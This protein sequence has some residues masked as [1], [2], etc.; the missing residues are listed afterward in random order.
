MIQCLTQ[1]Q[2]PQRP[3]YKSSS[4]SEHLPSGLPV[5]R[6]SGVQALPDQSNGDGA[7]R[8]SFLP[9]RGLSKSIPRAMGLANTPA[10]IEP[11]DTSLDSVDHRASSDP[12]PPLHQA[13]AHGAILG[14]SRPRSMYQAASARPDK[15]TRENDD[16]LRRAIRPTDAVSR[17]PLSTSLSRSQSLRRPG[18]PMQTTQSTSSR[19]HTR[20]QSTST[21]AGTKKGS[22]ETSSRMDRPKSLLM[23]PSQLTKPGSA[24]PATG[25]NR[26][27]AR[28]EA[29]K[30]SASTRA[31]ADPVRT[32]A[33]T[34]V[35]R[36]TTESLEL[37]AQHREEPKDELKRSARP[38]FTTL[39]QHFTPR[40]V[41]KAAT[42]TFLHPAP[43]TSQT[44]PSEI[45]SLQSELL[46]LHILHDASTLAS[47]K[48]EY[49]AKRS[50][51]AKFEKVAS[52]YQVMREN[53]QQAQEEKS[54]LA[55]REWNTGDSLSG[56]VEHIQALSGPLQ[57]L[58]SLLDSGGRYY[59]LVDEFEGWVSRA[60]E[61]WS[62]R[63]DPLGNWDA[64]GSLEGL[65][66]AWKRDNA[67]LARKMTALSR[68]FDRIPQP[69][70]GSSIADM[71]STCKQLLNEVSE[72]LQIMQVIEAGIVA[73][74]KQWVEDRLQTIARNVGGRLVESEGKE[75][76]RS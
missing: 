1:E 45:L 10:S 70:P 51:R 29:L 20:T 74:E 33:T 35:S 16:T 61:V 26:T 55:L 17:P 11:G 9:Q 50:L 32:R 63:Q 22:I 4:S 18:G 64:L 47:R 28:L 5:T 39:Q 56:L 40:K 31:K 34:D 43:D 54:L 76:W 53:E 75:A 14:R 66:D 8:R 24:V 65:G 27:S 69:T 46:Q 3:A 49:S 12:S 59:R 36:S 6:E 41:G 71:V 67:A 48:W 15:N 62:V 73:K 2:L 25:A 68:D 52:L 58:P 44:L 30:R 21:I 60:E 23:A 19:G 57:E 38:A 37:Q 42:S 72:E 13:D 7:K